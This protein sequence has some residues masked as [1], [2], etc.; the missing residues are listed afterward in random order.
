PTTTSDEAGCKALSLHRYKQPH[1]HNVTYS[2]IQQTPPTPTVS[3][4]NME[5][6]HI[7]EDR[8]T[9]SQKIVHANGV[10][11]AGGAA[12]APAPFG[13]GGN[14]VAQAQASAGFIANGEGAPAGQAPVQLYFGPP[15]RRSEVGSLF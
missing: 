15:L 8:A 5:Q 12:I 11:H 14:A 13:V 7:S 2:E 9:V 6:L 3:L 10:A 4:L 1:L